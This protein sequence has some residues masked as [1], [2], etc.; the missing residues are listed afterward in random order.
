MVDEG[1]MLACLDEVEP[2]SR[3]E[4]RQL[5]AN[6][7]WRGA[8]YHYRS[9]LF[10]RRW[11]ED[12]MA[13]IKNELDSD[14]PPLPDDRPVIVTRPAILIPT[15]PIK[16]IVIPTLNWDPVLVFSDTHIPS[17]DAEMMTRMIEIAVEQ[18]CRHWIMA[19]DLTDNEQWNR[20]TDGIRTDRTWQQDITLAREVLTEVCRH[21][22]TGYL[23]FGNHDDWIV[24]ATR[25]QMNTSWLYAN[26]IPDC[27]I[28]FSYHHQVRLAQ[29]GPG[30]S[31]RDFTILHGEHFSSANPLGVAI[32]YATKHFFTSVIVGHQHYALDDEVGEYQVICTG[33]CF[34]APRQGYL[35]ERPKKHRP[36]QQGFVIVKGG[37]ARLYKPGRDF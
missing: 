26:L 37:R 35:H 15:S 8:D 20:R 14:R 3:Q 19:G 11:E 4:A 22:P 30:M 13:I 23:F 31:R 21:I 17:H 16:P 9:W 33:G 29:D 6:R 7:G 25:G 1:T 5:F 36:T 12:R 10:M 2:K 34:C 24:K 28:Q 32:D 18:G 27:D